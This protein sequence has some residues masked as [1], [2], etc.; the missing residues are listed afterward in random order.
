MNHSYRGIDAA[1]YM[2]GLV[3][4][5]RCRFARPYSSTIVTHGGLWTGDRDSSFEMFEFLCG[6]R[7]MRPGE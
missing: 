1:E 5:G 6:S 4:G 7:D 2:A 3:P